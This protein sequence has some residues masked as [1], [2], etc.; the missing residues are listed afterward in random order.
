[1]LLAACCPLLASI[2]AV[3]TACTG[4]KTSGK[5]T[6]SRQNSAIPDRHHT[7]KQ[8]SRTERQKKRRLESAAFFGFDA[9]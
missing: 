5:T 1:L 4:R 7:A 3:N 2:L 6:Y 9:F 8:A